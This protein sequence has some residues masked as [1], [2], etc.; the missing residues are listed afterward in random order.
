MKN[1]TTD[2][3]IT[4]TTVTYSGVH[5]PAED[6]PVPATPPE[7]VENI[8]EMET[9]KAL[10][11][12]RQ[13]LQDAIAAVEIAWG[14]QEIGGWV[15]EVFEKEAIVYKDRKLW[16]I[17]YS[18]GDTISF[19]EMNTWKEV[20][21]ASGYTEKFVELHGPRLGAVKMIDNETMGAYGVLWGNINRKDLHKE[22]FTD[23]T[24]ELTSIFEQMGAIPWML[25]HGYD[26]TV[27]SVVVAAVTKMEPDNIGLWYEA[28]IK[29]HQIYKDYVKPLLDEEA[30]YSSSGTLP[31]AKRS[32][33]S[34]EIT[35]WP[36]V[37]MTGTV[38][39]AEHRMLNMPISQINK[40]YKS[41][42]LEALDSPPDSE[43]GKVSAKD[44]QKTQLEIEQELLSLELLGL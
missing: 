2:T 6:V 20:E 42:G 41:I 10:T 3:D 9:A 38:R 44:S 32:N 29:E 4:S 22:Y 23:K 40:H 39:P 16:R 5:A 25:E 11:L 18:R 37:E 7:V 26:D 43:E 28:K 30:L 24:A 15:A 14:S 36:I 31:A 27:K 13:S 12:G 34:G 21:P 35:R 1:L 33:Q 17:G 19:A 8:T